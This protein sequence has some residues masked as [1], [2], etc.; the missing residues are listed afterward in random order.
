MFENH[1]K[2]L[3]QH[4]ELRSYVYILSGQKIIE[5]SKNSQFWQVQT[6]L[7]LVVKQSYQTSKNPKIGGK[8]QN[9]KVKIR[10]LKAIL[11]KCV[12]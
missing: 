1:R 4:C 8:C 11:K 12:Q 10:H 2:S 6:T 3:I 5:N 9:P 7:N